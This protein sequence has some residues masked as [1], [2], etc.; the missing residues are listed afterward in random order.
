MGFNG[1]MRSVEPFRRYN[2]CAMK[3]IPHDLTPDF[4]SEDFQEDL[5]LHY[6]HYLQETPVFRS[7]EGVVYLARYSDCVEL[8]SNNS[9]RRSPPAGGCNPFS[10]S[11]RLQTPLEAMI[12]HWMLFM[13][14][15]RH[16]VVRKAF[17]QPFTAKSIRQLEPM[18]SQQAR[19]LIDALPQQ[20]IVELLENFAFP[21]PVFV[22]AEMLGVPQCDVEQ[23]RTWSVQLTIALDAGNEEDIRKG[24]EV[25]LVLRT[26]FT[27]LLRERHAMPQH[28]LINTLANDP[29]LNL[30]ADEL[31]YGCVFLLWAGHETTKNL[32]ANGIQIL[33]ERPAELVRLQL[34]PE[35]ME[36]AVEEMLRFDSPVQKV[37]RWTHEDAVFGDYAVPQGTLVTALIG[38][39]NRDAGVFDQP[40]TFDIRRAKNRHIAFGTGLHHC[41]GALLARVEARIAFGELVPRL[42]Q[43]E[44]VQHQWRTY[45][46]FRSLES[47]SVQMT[48]VC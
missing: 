37:S 26:Y 48:Q 39:A 12:S 25:S 44:P 41:L 35:L 16:D 2:V 21:L 9:F 40:D 32:I 18:I 17:M 13:D 33:A 7:N 3:H 31:L 34:H 46:A 45:S 8:L 27:D 10:G 30:S 14:P 5:Y 42:R 6:Q 1:W 47:L 20:G 43:L 23:F 28:C 15:P 36:S 24:A 22:I 29:G 38:A 11:R 19:Q 4:A